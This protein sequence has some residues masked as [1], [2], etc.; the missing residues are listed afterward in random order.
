MSGSD[1]TKNGIEGVRPGRQAATGADTGPGGTGPDDTG[2]PARRWRRKNRAEAFMVP[3]ATFTSYYG[4]PVI[5][6]PTWSAP[7]IPG[8]LFFCGLAGAGSVIAAG[9]QLTGRPVLARTMK[10]GCT[11]AAGLSLA[12]LVHDLGRRGR[13]LNMMRTFKVT[14]LMSVGSWVLAGYAPAAAASALSDLT[15]IAPAAGAAATATASVIG[16]GVATHTAALVANTAVPAWHDGYRYMRLA[17]TTPIPL[18]LPGL[19]FPGA[20][21]A[22]HPVAQ[23][24]H[25]PRCRLAPGVL[26]RDA[27]APADAQ[28]AFS[29]G[30]VGDSP[31]CR[32]AAGWP[33]VSQRHRRVEG[34]AVSFACGVH[35]VVE[36]HGQVS[37]VAGGEFAQNPG[38]LGPPPVLHLVDEPLPGRG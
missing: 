7:D 35:Q 30:L 28:A 21:S 3:E 32:G 13:F 37:P 5:N 15:G 20:G 1:V 22:L 36:H 4:K 8:Y 12:A 25:G 26:H 23:Q 24:G 29:E 16:P 11:V 33:G 27:L 31:A 38:Q 34:E 6:Q 2:Q 17:R 10:S 9:A 19:R 14:S 18:S